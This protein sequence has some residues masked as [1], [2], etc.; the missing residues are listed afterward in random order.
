[1]GVMILADTNAI[2]QIFMNILSNAFK[3]TESGSITL[4]TE[5]R[6]KD[7]QIIVEDTGIGIAKEDVP[8]IFE[9]MYRGDKSR[10]KYEGSG[11]GLTIV[12]KLVTM[13]KG[14]IEV[15]SEEVKGSKF[16]INLPIASIEK[17][18]QYKVLTIK[19]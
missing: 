2:K 17:S 13:H 11:L 19:A 14:Q 10:E 12:K 3:F 6:G 5:I 7:V 18:K 4:R 15:E 1:E 8:Y 9:R 16:I